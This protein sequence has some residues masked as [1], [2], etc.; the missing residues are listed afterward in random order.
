MSC[1]ELRDDLASPSGGE[2]VV[3]TDGA[4]VQDAISIA[5]TPA[6]LIAGTK[7]PPVGSTVRTADGYV[8]RVAAAG[9]SDADVANAAG[10]K[11]YAE[12]QAGAVWVE[13]F[14]LRTTRRLLRKRRVRAVA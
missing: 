8:F 14:G 13:Q 7:S 12:P 11:F 1:E 2:M 4:T 10:T 3:T 5:A 6:A 9:A